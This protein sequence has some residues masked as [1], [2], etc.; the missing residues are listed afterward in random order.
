MN[1]VTGVAG[2]E[3]GDRKSRLVILQTHPIQ[4]YAPVY[5]AL[6]K[7]NEV[8]VHVVYL[9]D[10]G[11]TPHLDEQFGRSIGWDV[12]L[13]E[14]YAFTILQQ[15]T[16]IVGRSFLQGDDA[17]LGNVLEQLK[18]DWILLY[19]YASAFIWRA[20]LWARRRGVRI[21]YTSDSNLGDPRGGLRLL[22]KQVVLRPFFRRIDVCLA[23]SE[24]NQAYLQH[25][26]VRESRIRRMPFAVD[27]TRFQTGAPAVG[28]PR[29]YDFLWA[30]KFAVHKRPCDF[31]AALKRVAADCPQQI[32]AAIVGEGELRGTLEVQAKGLPRNCSLEFVGFV[33]QR[34][35]P[36]VL[37]SA[38]TLVFTSEREA[39]GLIA[40][41]AAAAGLALILAD[42]I[43]CV[44]ATVLARPGINAQVYTAGGVEA[45]AEAMRRM[46]EDKT[47]L[48]GM[49]AASR[50]IAQQ[51]DATVAASVIEDV[52][53]RR[54]E[55]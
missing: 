37:Q 28:K 17:R 55:S 43:G 13:L 11:A 34:A 48:H 2:S 4:Y 7:R 41:E 40:T 22:A 35:M 14:G 54:G 32:R 19:G 51:H 21:A 31:L 52:V 49:Q 53:L 46:L 9:T 10:A 24:T 12:P 26:G 16:P 44:G 42:T 39:Y 8:D 47:A 36:S 3:A 45:L 30:G 38:D 29:K 1:V 6:A 20:V 15:G 27:V 23:T 18:P 5:A 33:N 25:Y 50:A